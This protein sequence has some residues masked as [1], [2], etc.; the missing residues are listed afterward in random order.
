M[1]ENGF[2]DW[3]KLFEATE[4]SR[5]TS[6]LQ[7][8][9]DSNADR[10]NNHIK[11]FAKALVKKNEELGGSFLSAEQKNACEDIAEQGFDHPELI[12]P[13]LTSLYGPTKEII[14]KAYSICWGG[15][16][17]S[18]SGSEVVG[19]RTRKDIGRPQ[20]RGKLKDIGEHDG[21]IKAENGKK[22]FDYGIDNVFAYNVFV[23]NLGPGDIFLYFNQERDKQI[24]VRAGE[25]QSL[26]HD[27]L[28]KYVTISTDSQ[29]K[30]Q[31]RSQ[32]GATTKF[33]IKKPFT[34]FATKF[35]FILLTQ[36]LDW[37]S[38]ENIEN[39]E[40]F[41]FEDYYELLIKLGG[42]GLRKQAMKGDFH[43]TISE[44]KAR[45][46]KLKSMKAQSPEAGEAISDFDYEDDLDVGEELIESQNLNFIYKLSSIFDITNILSE[47]TKEE[48][49][50][51]K[52]N[53]L[54][55]AKRGENQP[56]ITTRL[57]KILFR[58]T[59]PRFQKTYDS[60][61]AEEILSIRP[62]WSFK[63]GRSAKKIKKIRIAT[64]KTNLDIHAGKSKL[65][66]SLMNFFVGC[67][68]N[69][70]LRL[71]QE[72]SLAAKAKTKQ[73]G[74]DPLTQMK[75]GAGASKLGRRTQ[76]IKQFG[77]GAVD[78]GQLAQKEREREDVRAQLAAD[79]EKENKSIAPTVLA[80]PDQEDDDSRSRIQT[81]ITENIKEFFVPE[82]YRC[83][84]Q[85]KAQATALLSATTPTKESISKR[86][87][88]GL[89]NKFASS[90]TEEIDENIDGF[91]ERAKYAI[92][93]NWFG[94]TRRQWVYW[95]PT[96]FYEDRSKINPDADK[97][98]FALLSEFCE[99]STSDCSAAGLSG[100][101][102]RDTISKNPT[103]KENLWYNLAIAFVEAFRIYEIAI[104]GKSVEKYKL[105]HNPACGQLYFKS[106]K[107]GKTSFNKTKDLPE[108][109]PYNQDIHHKS[110]IENLPTSTS[111][112]K[113]RKTA[114]EEHQE[115]LDQ[116]SKPLIQKIENAIKSG[117]VD[118]N[119]VIEKQQ[120]IKNSIRDQIL[121]DDYL[122]TIFQNQLK[123]VTDEVYDL[124]ASHFGLAPK[125]T[126][127]EPIVTPPA[128]TVKP[129]VSTIPVPT[130]SQITAPSIAPATPPV[131][132]PASLPQ[133]T[134]IPP[135]KKP[136]SIIPIP[137]ITLPAPEP[138]V[139]P[140]KVETTPAPTA[141][142]PPASMNLQKFLDII[143]KAR[144]KTP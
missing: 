131:T 130:K 144:G 23:K 29:A 128:T 36:L 122:S 141:Q 60:E 85:T 78:L 40:N 35:I 106:V 14:Q 32:M 22:T 4:K 65:I 83:L 74:E 34:K 48:L 127:P 41:R 125:P 129:V 26:T 10:I 57:G 49:D 55:M 72:S 67:F 79:E 84:K 51:L 82:L 18:S 126:L 81:D 73:T 28:I 20:L 69:Q 108:E 132:P 12:K 113:V 135:E 114:S 137:K 30:Y 87:T 25:E 31:I 66:F 39:V 24:T 61:F 47:E 138:E 77:L 105:T 120:V 16:G 89:I 54:D 93:S 92:D 38:A 143:A 27:S 112:A 52:T 124:I 103:I 109:F 6:E 70:I 116:L 5:E 45:E 68:S 123:D 8:S 58:L 2:Y 98:L 119:F 117:K 96:T 46:E 136:I 97:E 75:A 140:K 21:T 100:I 101:R 43:D 11:D 50:E 139:E 104:S 99:L 94:K 13:Y 71:A 42:K 134:S 56:L 9:F 53:L 63:F 17:E 19:L 44:K 33:K 62:E 90:I 59:N 107:S 1:L 7:N 37:V 118:K 115:T 110:K 95:F 111:P 80:D 102:L 3:L 91:V 121:K 15:T 142:Q 64:A 86:F 88:L 133:Q 76:D